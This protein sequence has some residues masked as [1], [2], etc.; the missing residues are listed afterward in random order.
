MLRFALALGVLAAAVQEIDPYDQSKVPVEVEPSDASRAKIVLVAGRMSH[1]PG[2][3]EYFAGLALL[4]KML[5]QTPG[6][7]PVLVRDGW[8]KNEKVF[9][10]ARSIVFFCDGGGGHPLVQGNRME[11]IQ[12]EIDRG[13]GFVALHYALNFP[14]GPGERVLGWLG[15]HIL[16]G[17]STSLA[18]KWTAEFKALPEHP[19][20]RGVGPFSL[21]DEW[22]YFCRFVAGMK[23]V[24]PILKAVPPDSTRQTAASKEH[25]GREEVV[26]WVYERPGGGR[27]FGYTGGHMHRN[28]GDVSARRLVTNA[29]LW[30]AG[31]EVPAE[32]A[33]VD[34]NPADLNRNLD[35]KRKKK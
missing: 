1:G 29:I 9:A 21:H 4:M 7:A 19:V 8:P 26:A 33:P 10:N 32:G 5:E 12:K 17:Y 35:D 3:H 28:W 22:Y 6:V 25:A 16:G 20:T 24:T 14:A 27:A 15:G 31:V 18:T 23:G 11:V 13:A 2:D 34:L 30:T